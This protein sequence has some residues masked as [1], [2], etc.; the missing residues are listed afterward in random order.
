MVDYG[1]YFQDASQPGSTLYFVEKS[2]ETGRNGLRGL[3]SRTLAKGL[4]KKP[5]DGTSSPPTSI[6]SNLNRNNQMSS[7]TT[8]TRDAMTSKAARR[9]SNASSFMA[10]DEDAVPITEDVDMV[11][12]TLPLAFAILPAI[13]G[14]I[15]T[16]GNEF[17]TDTLLLGLAGLLLYWIIKF[18]WEWHQLSCISLEDELEGS[19]TMDA[20]QK[21][22]RAELDYNRRM[23]MFF[24]FIGPIAGGIFLSKLRDQLSR[25]SEGLI[26]DFNITIFV[27]AA[28]LRPL[29]HL[30]KHIRGKTINL[31]SNL[32]FPPSRMEGMQEQIDNLQME[33]RNLAALSEKISE[34]EGDLDAL[35]RA[36]RKYEKKEAIHSARTNNKLLEL[37][38]KVSDAMS[39]A[40]MVASRSPNQSFIGYTAD[41]VKY[42]VLFPI[43]TTTNVLGLITN[44]THIV[45][46]SGRTLHHQEKK[47]L[48]QDLKRARIQKG[49]NATGISEL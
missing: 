20:A 25:P 24:C 39:L 7:T 10:A 16:K 18:P 41:W 3:R 1:G 4:G 13:A 14:M 46:R 30:I 27:L 37:D 45:L 38:A 11:W 32:R 23:A 42:I 28:E 21:K 40:D 29:R 31:Q 17:V 43:T 36:V 15:F 34:R 22:V 49:R 33:F 48:D 8:V 9:K 35:H 26:S 6:N 44:M 5:I 2:K 19:Q 12:Y 47:A